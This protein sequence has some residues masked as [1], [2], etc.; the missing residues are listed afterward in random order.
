MSPPLTL[1]HPIPLTLTLSRKLNKKI[2]AAQVYETKRRRL[3]RIEVFLAKILENHPEL[4]LAVDAD[5]AHY[6]A[7]INY[8]YLGECVCAHIRHEFEISPTNRA[9]CKECFPH[10]FICVAMDW[11]RAIFE[12]NNRWA[13]QDKAIIVK[14]K[15]YE[16]LAACWYLIHADSL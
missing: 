1:P 9:A 12:E 11:D 3:L 13:F 2:C 4:D 14:S 10:H 8:F 16:R 6:T 5:L 15:S 7:L